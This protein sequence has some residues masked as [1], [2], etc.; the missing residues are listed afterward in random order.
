MT[1]VQYLHL[2]PLSKIRSSSNVPENG[3]NNGGSVISLGHNLDSENSCGFNQPSDLVNT[4][5]LL[6]PLQ[7]NGGPTFTCALEIGSPAIDAATCDGAPATDQRGVTRPQ[8]LTCDIGAYEATETT[9]P[10]ET[11]KTQPSSSPSMPSWARPLNPSQMS[12]QYVSVNPQ[13]TIAGQPVI[14]TTNVVNTGDEAGNLN[15]ALKINGL[16]EQ[17][18]MVSVGP[19]GTQ[20]V[21]FTVTKAQPGTYSVD[22]LGEQGSFTVLGTG[23][24]ASTPVNGG[25]I[26]IIIIGALVLATLMVLILTRRSA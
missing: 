13:Q 19:Q 15:I 17:S 7:D 11:T 5:P 3:Y 22:I 25:L 10:I 21:K 4:D 6:G 1:E 26:A 14:I 2:L 12:V 18:R 23:G 16:V 9:L 8:S 24:T 20:P